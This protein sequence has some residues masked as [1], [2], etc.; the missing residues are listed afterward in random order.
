MN[1]FT[2]IYLTAVMLRARMTQAQGMGEPTIVQ[3]NPNL[4]KRR[5]PRGPHV[6]GAVVIKPDLT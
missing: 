6:G 1:K 3:T 4:V 5:R 2:S